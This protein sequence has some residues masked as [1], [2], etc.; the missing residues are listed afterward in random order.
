MVKIERTFIM[1]TSD[2]TEEDGIR[3]TLGD[4]E[5]NQILLEVFGQGQGRETPSEE[6][7]AYT[8]DIEEAR[9]LRDELTYMIQ[10][11]SRVNFA[12]KGI[13]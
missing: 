1:R 9:I 3:L 12:N 11:Q 4:Q 7:V 2:G 5:D 13:Y 8:L 10:E 6:I